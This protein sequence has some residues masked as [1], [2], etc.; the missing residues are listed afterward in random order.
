MNDVPPDFHTPVAATTLRKQVEARLRQAIVQGHFRPGD[1]VSDRVMCEMFRVSRPVVREAVRQL[2][3]EGLLETLP[4]KGSFV[5]SM[6]AD[7]AARIYDVRGVLEALAARGFARNATD[8]QMRALAAIL[9]EL[10][11]AHKSLGSVD[12]LTIKQ[13]FY[14]QMLRG[15]GNEYVT[16]MLNQILNRST[17]L[18]ATSLSD[19]ARLPKSIA[20]LRV[21]MKALRE[22]D[23]DAAWKASLEHVRRAAAAALAVLRRQEPGSTKPRRARGKKAAGNGK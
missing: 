19:P 1:H 16:A 3:A 15:C 2:E 23:E 18:R 12:V 14:D 5:R 20:E 13:R 17:L 10:K 21:L 7:E 6:S 9:E 4:H 11:A 8:G 22:R